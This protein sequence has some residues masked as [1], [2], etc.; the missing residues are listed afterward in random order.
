MNR[1]ILLYISQWPCR[2]VANLLWF[3][4][5]ENHGQGDVLYVVLER[6]ASIKRGQDQTTVGKMRPII[7]YG[8]H[9]SLIYIHCTSEMLHGGNDTLLPD[10]SN[11]L[12]FKGV[13]YIIVIQQFRKRS[14]IPG[15]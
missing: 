5:V 11:C 1:P 7:R 4:P 6:M 12:N 2:L 13:M 10:G 15:S 14:F 3:M 9:G 8:H